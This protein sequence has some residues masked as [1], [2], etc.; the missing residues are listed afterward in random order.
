MALERFTRDE[1]GW[2]SATFAGDEHVELA[3]VG[4]SLPMNE[5]YADVLAS[6]RR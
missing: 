2:T 6:G 5:V 4:L 3:S 1:D